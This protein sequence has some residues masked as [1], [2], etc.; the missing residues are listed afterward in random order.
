VTVSTRPVQLQVAPGEEGGGVVTSY[1]EQDTDQRTAVESTGEDILPVSRSGGVGNRTVAASLPYMVGSALLPGVVWMLLG[2]VGLVSGREIDPKTAIKARLKA[3]PSD[4]D[5]R[6]AALESLFRDGAA[7]RL[8][9]PAPSLSLE[10]VERLG[11][12]AV[13]LYADLERVRYGGGD[14]DAL[15]ARVRRFVGAL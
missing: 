11:D 7:L 4:P 3:L 2:L 1:V 9:V 13:A 15:E 12:E 6:L 5:Q 14:A 8:G 10:Q